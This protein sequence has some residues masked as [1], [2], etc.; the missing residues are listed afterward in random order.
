MSD[1]EN[2]IPITVVSIIL[3][4]LSIPAFWFCAW[5]W[6]TWECVGSLVAFILLSIFDSLIVLLVIRKFIKRRRKIKKIDDFINTKLEK[7]KEVEDN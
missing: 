3:L 6:N 2:V 4:L 7:N 5:G 1:D